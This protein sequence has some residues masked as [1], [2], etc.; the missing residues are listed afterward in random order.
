MP[1]P[2]TPRFECSVERQIALLNRG[3]AALAADLYTPRGVNPVPALVALHGGGWK[4]GDRS[5]YRDLGEYLASRGIALFAADYRLVDP[6][7]GTARFP[8]AVADARDAV[9]FLRKHAASHGIDPAR[10]GI[11]GDSA[12]AHLGALVALA[13]N[14]PRFREA[15]VEPSLNGVSC[16]VRVVAGVYGVYDMLAQWEHDL[17]TRPLDPITEHFLGVSALDNR[18]LYQEAS[19]LTYVTTANAAPLSFLIA[20]G[21]ADDICEPKTQ[22]EAFLAAL[23]RVGCF[24]RS[25]VVPD[26]PHFWIGDPIDEPGSHSGFFAPRLM[27][28]LRERL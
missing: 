13:A 10:I 22:S 11:L 3:G 25:A 19:P 12:G 14:H 9:K 6:A 17:I 26:A 8:A 21:T 18:A 15:D 28:F 1:H 20:W 23:K 7:K 5:R 24:V 4:R 2:E 27:R 16:E